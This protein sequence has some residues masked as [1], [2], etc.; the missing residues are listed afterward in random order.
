MS[1]IE[2]FPE[3]RIGPASPIIKWAGGKTGLLSQ[4]ARHFPPKY[5][6]YFEP[7]LG[8][9]AVFFYLRPDESYLFD[10]NAQLIEVYEVVRN[11]SDELI[12]ALKQYRNEREYYYEVRAQEPKNLTMTER[13]ARFIFLNKTCYNGLYRVNRQGQFNVPF[14]KY[15]NPA[16]CDEKG[17]HAASRALHTAKLRVADFEIVLDLAQAGDLIYFDPPYEPLSVTSSFTG[18]TSEGF[19]SD[20]QRR[21]ASAYRTLDKR[22][23][24]LMLSNSS[25]PLIYELYEGYHAY[26]ILAR[27]AINS[28]ADGRGAITE[29]LV[30]NF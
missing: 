27:R 10:L 26:Q 1:Q 3:I 14:G 15:K 12:Q 24:L 11:N 16:I 18:Y 13:A 25:A 22:G 21:L 2:L 8:G 5:K 30:T 9:A 6:R 7:F 20:D 29:L 4:F 23:C 17:L 19:T 28:K